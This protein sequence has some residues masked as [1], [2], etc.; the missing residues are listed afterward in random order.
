MSEWEFAWFAISQKML[1]DANA[2]KSDVEGFT[3]ILR[4]IRG[5]EVSA[6]IFETADKKCRVN[7]RSKESTELMTLLNRLEVVGMHLHLVQC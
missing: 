1:K 2:S 7:F 5:V 4:S 6:M 3:D